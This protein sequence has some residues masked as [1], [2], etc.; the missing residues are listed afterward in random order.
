MPVW[1]VLL[2][3]F[4][5]LSRSLYAIYYYWRLHIHQCQ[6]LKPTSTYFQRFLRAPLDLVDRQDFPDVC[7]RVWKLGNILHD[8]TLLWRIP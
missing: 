5:M 3:L 8:C 6:W 4:R 7:L 1:H 2:S